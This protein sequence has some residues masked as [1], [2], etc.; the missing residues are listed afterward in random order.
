MQLLYLLIYNRYINFFL[1]WLNK[2][3]V[4][5]IPV[6]I[7]L[8]PSGVI[9]LKS[10]G[11]RLKLATNQT[12]YLT[13]LLFWN[14]LDSFEYTTI[15]V[16]LIKKVD[17]FFDVGSNIGYYALLASTM[18]NRVNVYSFEPARGAFT[19]LKKNVGLNDLSKQVTVE[20]FALTNITG[21]LIFQEV[22]NGKYINTRHTLSGENN[23]ATKFLKREFIEYQVQGITL[24]EYCKRNTIT[25]ISLI[26]IDTEG[27][28]P[29]ILKGGYKTISESHP[30]IICEIRF[31]FNEE[32]IENIMNKLG[33][34]CFLI[35]ENYLVKTD[36]LNR[37]Y[38]TG[39]HNF[40]F[41]HPHKY[42]LIE[43]FVGC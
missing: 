1:R 23:A 18:N 31:N 14:G 8:P 25:D 20:E 38:E 34:D 13:Q 33:Y 5:F 29:A 28:E 7:R 41:V 15:F 40:F 17:T 11:H 12:S 22:Q 37:A 42:S 43:E 36:T 16:N 9:Q 6:N 24:D 19:Y 26:K 35:R 2:I 3:V 39:T 32:K 30:I 27:S 21:P 10:K 4:T